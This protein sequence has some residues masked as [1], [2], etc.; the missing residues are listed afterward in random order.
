MQLHQFV[1]K[2]AAT[3]FACL[4]VAAKIWEKK[5]AFWREIAGEVPPVGFSNHKQNL[6]EQ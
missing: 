4:K 3:F 5:E 6:A 1:W 2:V